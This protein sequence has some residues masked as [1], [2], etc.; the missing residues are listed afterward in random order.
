M[1]K[2]AKNAL[3]RQIPDDTYT[4]NGSISSQYKQI[5]NAVPVE[6]AR[7]MGNSLFQSLSI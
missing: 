4:F 7:H 3:I 1:N 6:L 2:N 5:G